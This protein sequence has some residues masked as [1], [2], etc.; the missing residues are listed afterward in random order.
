MSATEA[1]AKFIDLSSMVGKVIQGDAL[2]VMEK[3]PDNSIDM[4]FADPP[5]NLKKTYNRYKDNKEVDEYL[6][7]CTDWI[8]E[9]VRITK[10]SG[11]IFIHN[12]PKWLTF[13]AT[14]LNEQAL[15]KHWIAW[16][17]MGAPRGRTLLPTHY[18]I[19]WYVKSENFKFYDIRAPHAR[20]RTCNGLYADYGGKKSIIHPYGTLVSDLWT[21]IHRIRHSK[22]RDT[23][24]CQLPEPLL[25]RL[26]LMTTDEDD[27]VLDPFAGTGTTSVAAEK[28]GRKHIGIDIDKD[29]VDISNSKLNKTNRTMING[30]YVSLFL[31]KIMTIRDKDY[32][33]IKNS[34]ETKT[35]MINK[36]MV[37]KL[38]L[39]YI[40]EDGFRIE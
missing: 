28:L 16:N 4:T 17:A 20:C 9:M 18:G 26:I 11:S 29:Y 31:K 33:S 6:A 39:P 23:H 24:P 12:I 40:R 32:E 37:K 14:Y 25:E 10:P 21:D 27:I 2:C 30:C 38:D 13:F 15:F 36:K 19:L 35:M 7:W 1:A 3:I 5:F 34:L 8:H 22:R